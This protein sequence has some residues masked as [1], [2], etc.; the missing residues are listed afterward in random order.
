ML[1]PTPNRPSHSDACVYLLQSAI[2][3]RDPFIG[4]CIHARIIKHGLCYRGGFLTNNLLNLYVKTGSSSDAHRLFDEMPLKT[5]FSW[6]SIL[7]AHAKAGNLDSARRVFNEIP[8]PDSVSWTTMIVGYNHLGLFKSAVH[9][10]LRMVSSGI[11]PTQLTFTNVLASCAAAQA[12]DVGKKVHSFVVKLGQSGVVPVANSL[13]N[14]YAKCGDSVMAKFCQFDLALALFD[15]MTDPDIVSWNSIITGYCHQGYD[16][17]ALETFSFMLKSSSLKPD[18]FTL[19]SV[20]SACANRESLKLGKQIHAH[21]VRAD[22]DIAGA[23]GNALISMYAKLGAVEVAHRIVEITSTPSLNVIAFTS[24]LDGYFKIGDIDPARAIFDSLKHRD[25]VAWIAVIVGYAQNGLISDALVLFRLM[26]R[27]GP[28][29]NNYTL[30]AI[31]SVISSLASLDHGKQLHAVAIRLEEVC[32]ECNSK[33]DKGKS[34]SIKDA[35]KI[36]NHICSYRDTLTWTSMILA[37]AQHGL[38]NEAIELFEKMLRINLKPD[39]ITYVGVLS[40]CTHVGL[41]EQGKSYFNLMKNV[42]NIEPTSSHYACMIDLLGRAGLLEE[43]YNFIR[44]MPIEGEPWCSGKGKAAYNIPPPYLRIAKSLRAMGYEV[45]MPIEPDVVA[46]G[47]FLSSCRVHKY[48]DLA[49]VAAEKLLLIDPNNSG[50]YSALA[51]TLSACGKWED[52]AKVRKSMK[53]KAVKKEQGFSWVQIKNNV[54]IFGV[55]DALHPQRDAIYPRAGNLSRVKEIIQ[56]YSNYETKDLLAKQNL[57]GETPLY[58]ASANGHALVIREI[59]KYL[60]LQTV[61]IAAKNGYDPFHIA[62][63]QGHLEVLRELLHSFPNLAMTTDLS[64]STALHTAATQGHIDVVN[65]LLESDSNLAKIARNN[66]K[67]V[68]HSAARMG[69][70]EVKGQTALHMAVKGQNEEI[71]MELVKPDPAVLSLEDNKG[72]TALH[73]ATK[74]GRTQTNVADAG[75]ASCVEPF[76]GFNPLFLGNSFMCEH[77][78]HQDEFNSEDAPSTTNKNL[79]RATPQKLAF[80]VG[81]LESL[82]PINL[83]LDSHTQCG[84]QNVRCLLSMEG[85]NINATNKAG[86][87]PLDKKKKTSYPI[88]QRL[89]AMRSHQGTTLPLHQGSPS[90]LR[91]AGAA[92][93]TDQRKPPN[94]S[95]QLKQTVSDIKHDVQ[96]QLQQTRQNGMR[97]Q[98][99]AKKLKKLHISGL[100]NVITSATVVAVLIATVAFA[101]IFTVPGQYVEGKTHGFSLGQANIANNAAFLIFFVFDSMALFISLAVV[102]VQ[103]SVVVIEQKTKKQLVF[104]IN[105]LMWMACLFISIAFISLTYVVVGSH[106]RWLAIYATVI[107]SLIMLSTIG[108]MCYCVILHRMEETKLRA[109]SRSFSMSHASDQEIL[110]SEYKRILYYRHQITKLDFRYREKR[111]KGRKWVGNSRHIHSQEEQENKAAEGVKIGMAGM[112]GYSCCWQWAEVKSMG[113]GYWFPSSTTK[114]SFRPVLVSVSAISDDNS[115][116]YTSSSSNGRKLEEEG[117]KG[118]GTTARDRRLLRIRQEKRQREYDRLN[119]YPAWAKVLE[120][121]CKDDAELRAVLGDSIGNPEL[122]RKRVEDRVRKKG[123]DFQ[124]SKTGSVLAFKVTFRDFN[125]LDSYIWFE[126]FGSPSDRDVNLIGNVIQSWYVMGR[127]G[128]FNSSNL[129]LA[130]SSV[131]YDPLYD[132]DKGFKVMPSSF[133]D[134]SDIEFQEN[135]GRVWVDLGTSDYFA[136]DVLLNCLTALSSEYLGIQQIVFG[137]RRMGDWEEGMTSPEYEKIVGRNKNCINRTETYKSKSKVNGKNIKDLTV[138]ENMYILH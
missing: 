75:I 52:A 122:M 125:P 40:A 68:L 10:F 117:I 127:L 79:G 98:K 96:S 22:V 93:S 9:A 47:S 111:G 39:H 25:V 89:F 103:T 92:N 101:A 132:A 123:R 23:V 85:I 129:Q 124:K 26:I 31:L 24:L 32:N 56:N 107:G 112:S 131:E 99:I 51:N 13:L 102:V 59:L 81:V 119:N 37:L 38:G 80:V 45:F 74:K 130:N 110:N 83:T 8:Q 11:S 109:E 71:L 136:I 105:K 69:H 19:G 64:N 17:K 121:A 76:S 108:S 63:K 29:P 134:I 2:K 3:S 57:E 46:W 113:M 82:R 120:N 66:G 43:A 97:V 65:L 94:A 14:M 33:M 138:D 104:V 18:K 7:S 60:D 126:L 128:A 73:I 6:N 55:E 87:T 95:K 135:W 54:H 133:H 42:H 78:C 67:T 48:V 115:H 88:A 1:T 91:D 84:T 28:K 49:K 36:F 90:V 53:D 21:I 12:L 44:N 41:V 61:S 20:L 116:S 27:E 4:R 100:N 72:N 30:A 58:V 114:R 35:R 62:A 106:S 15:Q 77:K 86:E 118:S 16:I 70:L 137:G 50:A 34:G 5:S